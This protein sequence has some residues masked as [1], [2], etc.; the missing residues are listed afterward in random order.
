MSFML[1][2]LF[3]SIWTIGH[4]VFT[5]NATKND[6]VISDILSDM[7]RLNGTYAFNSFYACA[8][9]LARHPFRKSGMK[10]VFIMT[11]SLAQNVTRAQVLFESIEFCLLVNTKTVLQ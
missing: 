4:S 11:V 9:A 5:F 6:K 2:M 10:F 1:N 8:S 7:R 3:L